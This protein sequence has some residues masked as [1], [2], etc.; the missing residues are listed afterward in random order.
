MLVQPTKMGTLIVLDRETGR[1]LT[2]N[3]ETPVPASDVPGER[4]HPT[5]PM[6]S[7]LVIVEQGLNEKRLTDISPEAQAYAR[8][9]FAKYRNEGFFTPPSRQG[10]L[11]MPSTRGGFGWGGASYD[12]ENQVLYATANEV[13]LILKINLVEETAADQ[14]MGHE[15]E[16]TAAVN[17]EGKNLYLSNCA[18]CHGAQRQG[19]PNAFPALTGLRERLER[20][21]V[22]SIIT[23]GKG[24]MPAHPQFSEAQLNNLVHYLFDTTAV[25][26]KPAPSARTADR[27][28]LER[29]QAVSGPGRLSRHPP[30]LGHPERGGYDDL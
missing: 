20:P 12:P 8:Q 13:A 3:Q 23:Q 17:Q 18:T 5:Q 21:Q 26:S 7:D 19:V 28:V 2:D 6:Q 15:G 16:V 30:P 27:Y 14:T 11:T 10:T 22:A 24:T 9:E 29:V 25:A 4:A 1:P